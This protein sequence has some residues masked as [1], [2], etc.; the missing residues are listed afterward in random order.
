MKNVHSTA[1]F[2]KLLKSQ[3]LIIF[4][5]KTTWTCLQNLQLPLQQ[6]P[7]QLSYDQTVWSAGQLRVSQTDHLLKTLCQFFLAVSKPHICFPDG[8]VADDG[9]PTCWKFWIAFPV[10]LVRPPALRRPQTS[11]RISF[12]TSQKFKVRIHLGRTWAKGATQGGANW[13]SPRSWFI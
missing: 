3:N 5:L 13:M 6:K 11:A 2:L 4:F 7:P 10:L 12:R 8:P 9:L 1:G